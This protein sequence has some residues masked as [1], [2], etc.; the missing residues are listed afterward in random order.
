[1][2][3]NYNI[4]NKK[5]KSKIE[6]YNEKLKKRNETQDWIFSN[7][8]GKP[9][10]GAPLRDNN[11][12]L[13]SSFK[14]ISNDNI[15]KYDPNVFSKGDNNISVINHAIMEKTNK[16]TFKIISSPFTPM[17]KINNLN[18][19]QKIISNNNLNLLSNNNSDI[20]NNPK[21]NTMNYYA[22]NPLAYSLNQLPFNYLNNS[23]LPMPIFYPI[24]NFN[25]TNPLNI[26]GQKIDK[27]KE[28]INDLLY[29]IAEKKRKEEEYKRKLEE[30]YK[31]SDIKN[32]EYFDI[33]KNKQ[34]NNQKKSEKK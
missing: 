28:Y 30:D 32:K 5:P 11:G 12:N 3:I 7:S 19:S 9:G 16:D 8:F 6:L 26:S 10:G 24:N 4:Y 17:R 27:N 15:F 20:Y 31:I 34:K 33:K 14:T 21:F 2:E 18:R 13:I 25:L 23:Y 22:I 1:M 29:Q